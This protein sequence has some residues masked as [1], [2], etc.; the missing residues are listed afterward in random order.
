MHPAM[1]S[2]L[3]A[4]ILACL[5]SACES[6][7]G[8]SLVYMTPYNIDRLDCDELNRRIASSAAAA[9]TQ[10]NLIDRASGSAAG[11]VIGSVV[12]GPEH[13]KARYQHRL[14]QEEAERKNCAQQPLIVLPPASGAPAEPAARALPPPAAPAPATA[15]QRPEDDFV[16][17]GDRR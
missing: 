12:Y 4:A 2:V 15:T 1:R 8:G 5:L 16:P 11:N 17:F 10:Q 6:H 13:G 14:Y 7:L 9:R 3:P